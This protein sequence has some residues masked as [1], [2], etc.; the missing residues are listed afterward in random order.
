MTDADM[1]TEFV[2]FRKKQFETG[3]VVR[4]PESESTTKHYSEKKKYENEW[5]RLTAVTDLESVME[6]ASHFEDVDP[7]K[8]A[9]LKSK[10]PNSPPSDEKFNSQD[11]FVYQFNPNHQFYDSQTQMKVLKQPARQSL[12]DTSTTTFP[13]PRGLFLF[14]I[15]LFTSV[16]SL[17]DINSMTFRVD[18]REISANF[19][20]CFCQLINLANRKQSYK[21]LTSFSCIYFSQ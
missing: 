12:P 16:L 4:A 5:N 9:R 1:K 10:L 15:N 20:F 6:R 13:F 21:Y 18:R 2:N 17:F 8:Y 11:N 14:S 7:D 3:R 19:L